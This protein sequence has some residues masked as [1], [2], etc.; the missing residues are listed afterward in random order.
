M[1]GS[2]ELKSFCGPDNVAFMG[3]LKL[4]V[5]DNQFSDNSEAR[6]PCAQ[7]NDKG[8][9]HMMYCGGLEK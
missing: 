6:K 1:Q 5:P 9:R 3:Q 8:Y 7:I 4:C 2:D